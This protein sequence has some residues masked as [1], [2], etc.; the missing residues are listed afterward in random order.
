MGIRFNK[1]FS[2]FHLKNEQISYQIAIVD[3]KYLSHV[4]WGKAISESCRGSDFPIKDR[5]FS[6]NPAGDVTYGLSMNTLPQEYPGHNNGDYRESSFKLTYSD[7]SFSSQLVYDGYE[8]I[9]G[10]PAIDGLPHSYVSD[11]EGAETLIVKLKDE[12]SECRINLIYT[13]F[14]NYPVI[15]RSVSIE[16]FGDESI[17]IDK[18][19]SMS[20]DLDH[21]EFDCIQLPGAWGRERDLVRHPVYR[22]VHRIDSKRGTTSHTYQ[23][24]IALTNPHTTED[25]GEVYGFHMVYS[26]EFVMNTEV[27]EYNQTRVQAGI[28]PEHFRWTLNPGEHFVTPEVVM[29]YS[30]KGLNAFSQTLHNFYQNQLIRGTYQYKER[31][32]LINNWEGTY[33]DFTEDKILEMADRAVE[34]GVELFV[35][36]DGWFGK[37]DDDTT[38]LGDWFVYDKKLPNSLKLLAEKIRAKGMKFGLWFEPEMISEESDLF[39]AHPD[40]VLKAEGRQP[41]KGRNQYI[42]DYSQKAVRDN[43][44]SQLKKILD[45]VP[46][47]YI[48]WDFNRNMSEIGSQSPGVSDGEVT[49]RYILG[50]YDLLEDL[51]TSYPDILWESCSGGGG[52]FDPGM[53]YY[54]PQT[55]TSDNTDAVARL[56]IQTGTSLVMPISSIG[57]HVSDVP[58]HQV[59]RWTSLDMRGHV[60]MSG[61]LGYELDPTKLSVFEKETVKRQINFYKK[62]RNLIQFGTFYRLKSPFDFNNETAWQFVDLEKS[63]SV[64][65]YTVILDKSNQMRPRLKLKGLDSNKRY[66]ISSYEGLFHGDELMNKGVYIDPPLGA[67]QK[68]GSYQLN[69]DFRSTMIKVEEVR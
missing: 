44:A 10:K 42:L 46:I 38:S 35:L 22:G 24:F 19:L 26:G 33:F 64:V 48:K 8:I 4:Y 57:A 63:Q 65:F 21:S 68:Q 13:I 47:D 58:N 16:N 51:T 39:K 50:L 49:H 25:S 2:S 41:S 28:N 31:P 32:V 61:N 27:T 11:S 54:M 18:L 53:L 66:K 67:D 40:W 34:L 37:R 43:I 12:S 6:P 17:Q 60:A 23:P 20:V 69:G 1:K 52:R 30:D 59:N 7:G 15:T 55:W 3:N 5:S 62:N 45:E 29:A 36:D 14:N 56:E 9:K